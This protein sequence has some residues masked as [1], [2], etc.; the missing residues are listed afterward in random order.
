M[1]D[2]HRLRRG[3]VW[4]DKECEVLRNQL[5]S[6]KTEQDSVITTY[7]RSFEVY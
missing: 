1:T 4:R 6:V 5:T 2:Y 7:Q 3:R